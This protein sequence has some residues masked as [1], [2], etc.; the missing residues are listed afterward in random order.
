M[1]PKPITLVIIL[2]IL[3]LVLWLFFTTTQPGLFAD[4][5][6]ATTVTPEVQT[7]AATR[8]DWPA[9][10]GLAIFGQQV[11]LQDG[12]TVVVDEA[13][14]R[15]SIVNPQAKIVAGYTPVMPT[16]DGLISEEGL[17]QLIAYIKSLPASQ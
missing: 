5:G 17:L 2:A 15:E 10:G 8:D 7:Q 4:T 12:R 14:V 1:N 3:A 16:F 9:P 6:V 13:Y 11:K